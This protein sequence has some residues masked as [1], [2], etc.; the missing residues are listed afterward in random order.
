MSKSTIN[1]VNR[2]ATYE[3]HIL[4]KYVAGMVLTGT[5]IKSIREGN[6]N[7]TD[8][9]C[10]FRDSELYVRNVQ[11]SHYKQGNIQNHEPMRAR[12][13]LLKK[14]ELKKL[15]NKSE[16]KGV[17]IIPLKIFISERGYAKIEIALAQGKM[18]AD[19][20]EDIK[21]RDVEREIARYR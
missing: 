5:E 4:Q 18:K 17:T 15:R 20:R 11:I 21:K 2:R 10:F 14:A 19:K 8:G 1:I 9:F 3:Y 16:D 12:K 6:V 7:L 13:L